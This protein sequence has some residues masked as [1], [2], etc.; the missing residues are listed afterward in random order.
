MEYR[1]A[2]PADV[3][4][5]ARLNLQLIRDEGEKAIKTAAY[6]GWSGCGAVTF[7]VTNS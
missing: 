5:L 1:D 3:E 2:S 4:L 7:L 6:L